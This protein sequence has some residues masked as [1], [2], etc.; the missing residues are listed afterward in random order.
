VLGF[1]HG[2][3]HRSKSSG[4]GGH[5]DESVFEMLCGVDDIP[6]V[7]LTKH[8]GELSVFSSDLAVK[9]DGLF[10]NIS[11]EKSQSCC[12]SIAAGQKIPGFGRSKNG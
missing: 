6:D 8:R 10:N 7:L 12:H 4:I 2:H 5:E 3:S 11:V 9:R 1:Y